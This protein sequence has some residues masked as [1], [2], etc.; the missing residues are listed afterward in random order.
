MLFHDQLRF[1]RHRPLPSNDVPE[2]EGI[3][4]HRATTL[5]SADGASMIYA[6]CTAFDNSY[7]W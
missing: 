5:L 3:P 6:M 4:Q 1:A 7:M 2:R